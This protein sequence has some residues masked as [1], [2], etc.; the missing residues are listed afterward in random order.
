M[1]CSCDW[2]AIDGR[3]SCDSGPHPHP[4]VRLG[5]RA[6]EKL[7]S[8][9]RLKAKSTMSSPPC[10]SGTIAPVLHATGGHRGETFTERRA[11]VPMRCRRRGDQSIVVRAHAAEG[12]HRPRSTRSGSPRTVDA[13]RAA[14]GR[15]MTNRAT[16]AHRVATASVARTGL[17]GA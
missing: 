15:R 10:D 12:Q 5:H 9:V 3:S 14:K 16:L 7:R 1:T 11:I 17:P 13:V 8:F 4:F 2:A 6:R